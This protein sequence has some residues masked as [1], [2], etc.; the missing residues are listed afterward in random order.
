MQLFGDIEAKIDTKGRAFLPSVFRKALQA[1]GEENLFLRKDL[2]QPCLILYPESEWIKQLD[3]VRSKLSRWN[4]QHQLLYR[5][6]VSGVE[7]LTLDGNGRILI[8]KRYLQMA[9]I[10]QSLQFLGLGDYIEIWKPGEKEKPFLEADNFS[11]A[12]E[13]IMGNTFGSLS[14]GNILNESGQER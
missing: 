4:R 1:S 7:A 11:E 8:P 5:Q 6:F 3:T 13:S 2:F 14:A 10:D 12:I 9:S